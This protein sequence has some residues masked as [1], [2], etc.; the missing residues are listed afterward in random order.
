MSLLLR[1]KL[2]GRKNSFQDDSKL[3][4]HNVGK[5]ILFL[6]FAGREIMEIT[7][8]SIKKKGAANS[9]RQNFLGSI[10]VAAANYF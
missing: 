9:G 7:L 6:T 5:M 4:I 8:A 1:N 2:Q 3:K 10:K